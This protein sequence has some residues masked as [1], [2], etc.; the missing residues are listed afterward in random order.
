[1]V[2]DRGTSTRVTIFGETYNIKSQVEPEYT[3]RVAEHVD[4]AMH[5]IKKKVGLQDAL[6]IAI[7]ASMSITDELFQAKESTEKKIEEL[8][9]KCESLINRIEAFL[10]RHKAEKVISG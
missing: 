2:E 9:T 7:L 6:K 10:E 1:M 5:A 8:E 4:Q 3:R